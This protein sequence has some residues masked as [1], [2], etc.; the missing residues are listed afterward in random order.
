[1]ALAGCGSGADENEASAWSGVRGCLAKN[2]IKNFEEFR[3]Q[4]STRRLR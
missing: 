1:M 3:R 2:G 4:G